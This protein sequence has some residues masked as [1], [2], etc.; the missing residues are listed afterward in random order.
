[1][2]LPK[3]FR[4]LIVDD[5]PPARE[6]L[7]R[8]ISQI[9]ILELCGEFGN[10]MQALIFLKQQQVDLLF[11]DIQ[12]PQLSGIDLIGTLKHLPKI[13]L[14]TAFD[15][16]AVQAFEL[17]VTDYLVKPIQFDRFLKAVMK[18]LPEHEP[19]APV[20]PALTGAEPISPSFL[21]FRADRKMVKVFLKEILYIES[22]KDYVKIH[23]TR[24]TVVTKHAMTAL[25][26]MLPEESFIRV[27]RS[28][29]VALDKIDSY[30]KEEIGIQ[31]KFI[32][33]GKIYRQ[34][35]LKDLNG[36]QLLN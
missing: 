32:P 30:T 8:Y 12:M 4:C 34:Q 20:Q 1:M 11:L 17:D 16:Y 5:E 36:K 14:T 31:K 13:V 27:H 10:A 3:K 7:R 28:F 9:P 15:Q 29:I 19:L 24:G 21:Y 6:V 18:A 26:A 2:S 33:I 22:L 35:V 25:E 23:T